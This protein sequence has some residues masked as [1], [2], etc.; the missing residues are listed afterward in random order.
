MRVSSCSP[1][2]QLREAPVLG[3]ERLVVEVDDR[4]FA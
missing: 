4:A 3:R 1:A 2:L